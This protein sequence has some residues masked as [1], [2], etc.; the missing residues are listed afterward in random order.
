MCKLEKKLNKIGMW[1][2]LILLTFVVLTIIN[3]I[4][5]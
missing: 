3:E 1:F 4:I 2:G 5:L